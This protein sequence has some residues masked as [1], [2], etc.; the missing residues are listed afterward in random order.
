MGIILEEVPNKVL[1]I[2][3]DAIESKLDS[4]VFGLAAL[5]TG[6]DAIEAKLDSPT[7]G[8]AALN[9]DIDTLL[10]RLSAARAGYLDNI[11]NAQLLNIPNLST[12]TA[13]RIGYLDN[14]N[15]AGLL[16]L[17]AA[18]AGY[19]DQINAAALA[20]GG[21]SV[22]SNAELDSLTRAIADIVR[23]GGTGDLA[24]ILSYTDP[25]VAGRTQVLEKTIT[26]AANAGNV[27]VAT[28][29]SQPCLIKSI[30]IHADTAQTANMTSCA[31]Y[32]G[33][34]QVI[35][36]ISAVDAVQANL[37]AID[38]QVAWAGGTGYTVRLYTGKTIV[39]DLVGTGAAAVD[40][41]I[42]IAYIA[43]V[44]GGYLT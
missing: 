26:S 30:V 11:N 38:K 10:V 36:F 31:V 8:L 40:L 25:R 33:A 5:D 24:T 44:T 34:S 17:T 1:K 37:N 3:I 15:Q 9:A 4:P 19:L 43:S 35:T 6:V 18:R 32:G 20:Q 39:I 41:T 29:T 22:A 7:F 2:L 27:T 14:I 16:Q 42:T 12:L 13:A 21:G 28:V 23:A